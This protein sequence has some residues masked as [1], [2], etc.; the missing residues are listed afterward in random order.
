ML[1]LRQDVSV[2][3]VEDGMVLLDEHTGR[4]FQVNDSGAVVLGVLVEGGGE[5][6]AVDALT[7]RYGVPRDRALADVGKIVHQLRT[8]GLVTS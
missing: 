5:E 4:Y 7:E 8:T 2:V 3:T 6:E 1:N